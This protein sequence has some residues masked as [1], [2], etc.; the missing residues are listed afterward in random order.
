[1]PY[2]KEQIDTMFSELPADVKEAITSVDT[3]EVINEL[4]EKYKLHIDQ[5]GQLSAQ[6]TLVMAGAVSPQ[7]FVS[8]I[9]SSMRIP[10]ETAQAITSE[11]NKKVFRT[12]RTTLK[13]IQLKENPSE[14]KKE[15]KNTVPQKPK[16]TDPY[17]E[18]I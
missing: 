10:K 1:M 3:I 8:D 5:I 15:E 6:I 17:R 12:I 9:E 16:I 13:N 11:V 7:R 2:S 18:P 14:L 4:K